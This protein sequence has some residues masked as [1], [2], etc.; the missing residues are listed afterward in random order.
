M[1]ILVNDQLI[2]H[3]EILSRIKID[4]VKKEK[5]KDHLQKVLNHFEELEQINVDGKDPFVNPVWD[6]TDLFQDLSHLREDKIQP[7]LA[8]EDV[9]LN[10]P[11]KSLNQFKLEAVLEEE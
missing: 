3:L 7:S 1:S 4:D 2:Q 6:R 8:V 10:A 9:L 11:E 5:L